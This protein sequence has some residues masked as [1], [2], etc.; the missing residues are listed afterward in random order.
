MKKKFTEQLQVMLR[1]KEKENK[2]DSQIIERNGKPR[3][4]TPA[5]MAT[6]DA[7]EDSL[8]KQ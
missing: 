8:E 3:I 2:K 1:D 6:I 4:F 5:D 7:I